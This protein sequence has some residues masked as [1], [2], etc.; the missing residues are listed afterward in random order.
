MLTRRGAMARR[1]WPRLRSISASNASRI[2]R[3]R[4]QSGMPVGCRVARDS[5]RHGGAGSIVGVGV[6]VLAAR[7][8]PRTVIG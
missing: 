1:V 8:S 7:T 6:G 4:E 3:C 2:A 5:G